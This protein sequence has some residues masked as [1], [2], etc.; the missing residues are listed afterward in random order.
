M[1]VTGAEPRLGEC[2][3]VDCGLTVRQTV[4]TLSRHLGTIQDSTVQYSTVK[5]NT[6]IL[7]LWPYYLSF[8][9]YGIRASPLRG[10]KKLN[11]IQP[12]PQMDFLKKKTVWGKGLKN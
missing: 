9:Q 4:A 11:K 7:T 3:G 1:G 6:N 2:G 5:Y 8:L 12:L 10:P